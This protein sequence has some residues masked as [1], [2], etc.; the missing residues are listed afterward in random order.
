MH[1][2]CTRTTTLTH[3][4]P[5]VCAWWFLCRRSNPHFR[6]FSRANCSLPSQATKYTRVSERP[7]LAEFL[8]SARDPHLPRDL[9]SAATERPA[10]V[11]QVPARAALCLLRLPF[12]ARVF[13]EGEWVRL[14]VWSVDRAG[15]AQ[16]ARHAPQSNL[17]CATQPC[18]MLMEQHTDDLP[19]VRPVLSPL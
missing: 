7:A 5:C 11:L 17:H 15:C 16:H 2:G 1:L 3:K 6:R 4:P 10:L 9:H 18:S 19:R 12:A 8:E 14:F 13:C